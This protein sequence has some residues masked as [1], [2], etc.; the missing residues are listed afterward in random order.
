MLRAVSNTL[1]RAD[2]VSI[3][4]SFALG[5][6]LLSSARTPARETCRPDSCF[7]FRGSHVSSTENVSPSHR[8]T[9]HW[10]RSM[11][12]ALE[13]LSECGSLETPRISFVAFNTHDLCPSSPLSHAPQNIQADSFSSGGNNLS[14]LF[15]RHPLHFRFETRRDVKLN[16]VCHNFLRS[17]E[18]PFGPFLPRTLREVACRVPRNTW[19]WHETSRDFG[20]VEHSKR[21]VTVGCLDS[22][23]SRE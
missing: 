17:S 20:N 22:K 6:F 21:V 7:A 2:A 18:L 3:A 1:T 10:P 23:P 14:T 8:T 11:H 15:L 19:V 13:Q 4:F 12:R 16:H 5:E 9:V